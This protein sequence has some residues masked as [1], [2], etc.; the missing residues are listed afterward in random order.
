MGIL[1][2]LSRFV[3]GSDLF[4]EG[5]AENVIW[6]FDRAVHEHGKPRET[7]TDHGSVFWSVRKG[8][9]SFTNTANSRGSNIFLAASG[10]RRRRERLSDGFEPTTM[11]M[12]DSLSTGNSSTTTTGLQLGATAH[13]V[14]LFNTS[15]NLLWRRARCPVVTQKKKREKKKRLGRLFWWDLGEYRAVVDFLGFAVLVVDV[16]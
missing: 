4:D 15:R 10:N 11:N 2:D 8:E 7:L 6:L 12:T 16:D 1:D 5:T 3:P 14:K 13:G 9:S